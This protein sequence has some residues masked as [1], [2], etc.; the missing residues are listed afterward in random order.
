MPRIIL[1]HGRASSWTRAGP[2][3]EPGAEPDAEPGACAAPGRGAGSGLARAL[4][5]PRRRRRVALERGLLRVL[6]AADLTHDCDADLARVLQLLLDPL[7]DVARED[8]GTEI[9]DVFG[10]D[11]DADLAT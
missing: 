10:L 4:S 9:V 11:H 8:L 1:P 2:G 5:P 3:A 6:D 7:G